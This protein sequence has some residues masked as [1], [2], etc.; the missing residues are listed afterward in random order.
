[1]K[2]IVIIIIYISFL[3]SCKNNKFEQEATAP[4]SNENLVTLSPTQS[5]FAD[6]LTSKIDQKE[7]AA[8]I[9]VNGK[10]DVPP[11]NM[12]SI[13]APLGGYLKSTKLLPGMHL[14]KGEV[15]A[16]MEDQQYIELQQDYLLAKSKLQFAEI[17]YQRQKELNQS[18][19]SSDKVTQQAL[20]ETNIQRIMMNAIAEKLKLIHINPTNLSENTISKSITIQSPINGYVSKVNVNIGK[21]ITASEVMFEL[22]NPT[23]FHLNIKVFE[24]DISNLAI[25]QKVIAYTNTNPEKKYNCKILLINKDVDSDGTVD[26]HCHFDS[27]D[28]AIL[29]GMYMNAIIQVTS[30]K[31]FVIPND[32]LVHFEGKDYVFVV[33]K[34]NEY[35][36]QEVMLKKSENELTQI[37]FVNGDQMQD[38]VFVTKGA[39][40]LL[41]KMKN[42]AEE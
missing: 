3:S 15:I 30:S 13:S 10:I 28:K 42:T 6:I 23:D 39:Y 35:L 17:E 11:Q 32:G 38:K 16:V 31:S 7:M 1:M 8:E 9:R 18:Q 33:S 5:Q 25:G 4:V 2:K 34:Q 37:E 29:P 36:M 22:I 14:G 24:K 27:N 20:S 40:T 41:M 19:A 12:I 21:Y 26:V